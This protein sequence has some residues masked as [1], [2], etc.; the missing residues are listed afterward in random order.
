MGWDGENFGK[1]MFLMNFQR[2]PDLWRFF[3]LAICLWRFL[4]FLDVLV[5]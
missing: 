5:C 3:L 4:Y 2:Y 1:W